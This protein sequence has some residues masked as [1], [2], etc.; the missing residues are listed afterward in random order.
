MEYLTTY[1]PVGIEMKYSTP[2]LGDKSFCK[3]FNDIRSSEITYKS[4]HI[5]IQTCLFSQAEEHA[6]QS[7]ICRFASTLSTELIET[8]LEALSTEDV[9]ENDFM[10]TEWFEMVRKAKEN[11][12]YEEFERWDNW[13][14][15]MRSL[16]RGLARVYRERLDEKAARLAPIQPKKKKSFFGI[17]DL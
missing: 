2:D 11:G 13:R 5:G 12:E 6:R 9:L 1:K 14:R 7:A 17:F 15:D 10:A 3:I 16:H 8:Q 4:T